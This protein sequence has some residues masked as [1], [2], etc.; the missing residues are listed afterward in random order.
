M[1]RGNWQ[2]ELKQ[3]LI[4]EY[5]VNP[6]VEWVDVNISSSGLVSSTIISDRLRDLST[7]ERKNRIEH[8]LNDFH[9][10]SGFMS[11]YTVKEADAL[12]LSRPHQ[13]D[14]SCIHTWHD[15]ALWAANPQNNTHSPDLTSRI[16][17][18]VTFYSFKGGVGRTTALTHVAWILA[19]RG[20]KVVAVDL[21]LE[22]P[23]LSTAFKLSPQPKYGIADY[24]YERAYLPDEIEPEI[25]IGDIFGEVTIDDAMGRLFIVPSGVLSLDYITK[26]DDLRATTVN[27][28][29]ETLWS[30]FRNEINEQL[31]PDIILIDSR[32]GIN[33]WGA[34]S[35]LEA[36]DRAIVFLFPNEQNR[37]GI[38][39][40]LSSLNSFGKISIDFVF[41]PV[42]DTTEIGLAKI[43]SIWQ[44]LNGGSEDNIGED[45]LESDEDL[46]ELLI[47][48]YLTPIAIAE[49]YPVVGLLD[50]YNRIANTIDEEAERSKPEI[51]GKI[52]DIERRW[53][54]IESLR[55][56]PLNAADP[57]QNLN[58]LFQKTAN[59]DNFLDP[60]TCLIK[61]RKGTGKTALYLLLPD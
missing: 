28:H 18:T 10:S 49:K 1:Q 43:R 29:G 6:S 17:H 58:D 8:I 42:P 35:L 24:F 59:F 7:P 33:Q 37:Q 34:L 16:P 9:V 53:Q 51:R 21:D 56:P 5:V 60:A 39:I 3:K 44:S 32:T 46:S 47:V 31:K 22:A 45:R 54:I 15:L 23:G 41:S 12:N 13:Q 52:T 48:P 30:I 50:Y 61:G 38:D 2:H 26:V 25:A 36:A 4:S 11:L 19:N 14:S 40:L 55:F 57:T 20:H 27:N